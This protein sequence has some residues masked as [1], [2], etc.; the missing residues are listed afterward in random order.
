[1][2]TVLHTSASRGLTAAGWLVGRHSFSFNQWY[3]PERVQFGALRV[4][5]D[6]LIT[7]GQGFPPHQHENMEIVTIPLKGAVA[8]E[9]SSGG[10]G[11]VSAGEVQ[12]MSA[13]TG[14]THS[15]FN[16]SATEFL[17]LLQIWVL[18]AQ[19][20]LPPR[21]DEQKFEPATPNTWQLLVSP[22]AEAGSLKIFQQAWFARVYITPDTQVVYNLHGQGQG[23][24]V[25]VIEGRVDVAGQ[26]LVRR[27]GL[28][29]R[30]A[31]SVE[32][33]ALADAS[34]LIIEVPLR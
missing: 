13:G 32:I 12:I 3:N 14:V 29:V 1:M 5:N 31:T 22:D 19:Q 9:D 34:V 7:A 11:I 28:E 17:E 33:A 23:L 4:L 8:H 10:K 18:P 2:Q 24:Y 15:E 25:F 27:D 16:A 26:L 20:G 6:D 21:Y 30:D